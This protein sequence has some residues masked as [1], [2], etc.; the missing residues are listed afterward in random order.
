MDKLEAVRGAL[1][2]EARQQVLV[3][4]ST[5]V[6][7]LLLSRATRGN[8]ISDDLLNAALQAVSPKPE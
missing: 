1:S 7:A 3:T 5:M 2:A 4:L 8:A 6:G